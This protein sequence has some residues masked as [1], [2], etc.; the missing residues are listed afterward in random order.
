M[1]PDQQNF[2]DKTLKYVEVSSLAIKQAA[3]ALGG[4]EAAQKQASRLAPA[5]RDFLLQNGIIASTQKEACDAMLGSHASTLGLLMTM[6]ERL[7]ETKKEASDAGGRSGDRLGH[8]EA[9]RPGDRGEGYDSLSDPRV[10]R[11]T[12]EKKASDLAL[13]A[14]V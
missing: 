11:P 5:V 4:Y 6:G 9:G 7:V 8:G 1:L 12:S 10:G 2:L 14:G 13:L 3:D